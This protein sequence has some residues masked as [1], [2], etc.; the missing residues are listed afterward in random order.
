MFVFTVRG[1][2]EFGSVQGMALRNVSERLS[3]CHG[4]AGMY[5][6]T[7]T[8]TRQASEC[9]IICLG[10]LEKPRSINQAQQSMLNIVC[11]PERCLLSFLVFW[12]GFILILICV[13]SPSYEGVSAS[14][15]SK[16]VDCERGVLG[17]RSIACESASLHGSSETT[18]I[19]H[20][21]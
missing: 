12:G 5:H 7:G 20:L 1:S 14:I 3:K 19:L 18:K 15:I 16:G 6:G 10:K 8:K 2:S 21:Q 4:Q 17:Q 9:R 13:G 11:I